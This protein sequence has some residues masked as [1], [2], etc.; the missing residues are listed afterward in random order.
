MRFLLLLSLSLLAFACSKEGKPCPED[1]NCGENL[2]CDQFTNTCQSL[3]VKPSD[4]G[5]LLSC[6]PI[7]GVCFSP[8]L[9]K[10]IIECRKSEGCKREGE[11]SAVDGRCKATK[12]EDCAKSFSSCKE[13]GHCSLNPVSGY[14]EK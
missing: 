3:C 9:L 14:C 5:K 12:D 1:G 7:R 6:E 13:Y 2:G 11:C 10:K 8:H 4:C